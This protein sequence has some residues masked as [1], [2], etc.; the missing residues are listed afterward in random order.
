LR[1]RFPRLEI[2]VRTG[3]TPDILRQV[4]DNALDVGLVTLPAPGRMFNITPIHDDELVAIFPGDGGRLPSVATASFLNG[5]PILV[6]ESGGNARRVIDDWFLRAGLSLGPV[7]ELGN[8]EAIKQLVVAGLGCAVLPRIAVVGSGR[9]EFRVR[10]LSPRLY[11]RLGIVVRRDKV[12][13]RGL[14]QMI[15]ALETLKQSR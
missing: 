14:R 11:R 2:V 5:R 9:G 15:R 7:M 3:N 8:V 12:M 10:P 13:D 1:Q 4:E 6:Y